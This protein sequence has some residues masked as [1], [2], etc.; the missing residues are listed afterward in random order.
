MFLVFGIIEGSYAG[1]RPHSMHSS[2]HRRR[3]WMMPHLTLS[4]PGM[5]VESEEEE[6]CARLLSDTSAPATPLH[7][8]RRGSSA[9]VRPCEGRAGRGAP[10]E[11][12]APRLGWQPAPA[13]LQFRPAE[14]TFLAMSGALRRADAPLP[15]SI[16]VVRS[17]LTELEADAG[18]VEEAGAGAG[19]ECTC[20][21]GTAA[22]GAEGSLVVDLHQ[23]V[24]MRCP[25]HTAE[26]FPR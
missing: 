18:E 4:S 21:T 9:A 20:N 3:Q 23:E 1:L 12:R 11:P 25:K 17:I 16:E 7:R 24:V 22:A 6:E 14:K 10:A 19:A 5:V 26:R 2:G 13:L 15:D 8:G